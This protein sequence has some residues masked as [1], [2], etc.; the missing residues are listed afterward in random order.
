MAH[1]NSESFQDD[2]GIFLYQMEGDRRKKRIGGPYFSTGDADKASKAAS[3]KIG[4]GS[5]EDYM[6]F[7]QKTN[8]GIIG[9]Q[10]PIPRKPLTDEEFNAIFNRRAREYREGLLD[11]EEPSSPVDWFVNPAEGQQLAYRGSTYDPAGDS[12]INY[13]ALGIIPQEPESL[14]NFVTDIKYD[15]DSYRI[16]VNPRYQHYPADMSGVKFGTVL[17]DRNKVEDLIFQ[18][19]EFAGL[20]PMYTEGFRTPAQNKLVRGDENSKHLVGQAFD[21]SIRGGDTPANRAYFKK[22][23]ELLHP[24][25]FGLE[26][27]HGKNHIHVQK[28]R[29][30]Q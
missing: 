13:E 28:P 24:L 19:A 2:D 9:G 30:K 12:P 20:Q 22:L 11:A 26:Y 21:L 5:V 23:E 27:F 15:P 3:E 17:P 6:K 10:S 25:G 4:E 14:F 7:L 16:P 18:A 1:V 8:P 29:K